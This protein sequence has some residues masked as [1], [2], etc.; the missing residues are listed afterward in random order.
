[1]ISLTVENARELLEPGEVYRLGYNCMNCGELFFCF[2]R[3]DQCPEAIA[4]LERI[5]DEYKNNPKK[6]HSPGLLATM[7]KNLSGGRLF[8]YWGFTMDELMDCV[9]SDDNHYRAYAFDGKY[10]SGSGAEPL[11]ILDDGETCEDIRES[12]VDYGDDDEG[13]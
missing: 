7:R 9:A 1:M 10:C 8:G 11:W 6:H 2:D 4:K 12:D 3:I 13:W 5:E